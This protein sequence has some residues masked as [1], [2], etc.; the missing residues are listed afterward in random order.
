M[1]QRFA[2]EIKRLCLCLMLKTSSRIKTSMKRRG[3]SG[4]DSH[5][6][7]GVIS[8]S[9]CEPTRTEGQSGMISTESKTASCARNFVGRLIASLPYPVQRIQCVKG[10]ELYVYVVREDLA[11]FCVRRSETGPA[12]LRFKRES[13]ISRKVGFEMLRATLNLARGNIEEQAQTL[14]RQAVLPAGLNAEG[15]C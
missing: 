15:G 7:K 11:E 14:L 1:S 5:C 2:I 9:A 4:C 10:R 3:L 12:M 13:G 8:I 6:N